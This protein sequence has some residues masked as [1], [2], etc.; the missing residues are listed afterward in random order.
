MKIFQSTTL[1]RDPIAP[2]EAATKAY[3]DAQIT[4]GA[5]TGGLFFINTSPT[6][7]GIVG[8]KQYVAGTV[9]ANRVIL[10]SVTDTDN[11]TVTVFAE[12]GTAFYSP[13]VTITTDPPQ[14][15]GDIT[16]ILTEDPSDKRAYT[17]TANIVVPVNTTVYAVSSTNATASMTIQR[18]SAGPSIDTLTIT[19]IVSPGVGQT[20][21]RSGQQITV[22]GRVMNTATYAEIIVGGAA[23][24]LAVLTVG[25]VDSGGTGWKTITG[26]VTVGNGSGAQVVTARGRNSLGTF[27]ANFNSTNTITLNQT[28]P[29]I[30][31]RTI[32]YPG[33]QSGL[34]AAESA[35]V[36]STVSNFDTIT[37]SGTN[38]TVTNPT[39]YSASK[40]VTRSGGTYSFGTN[41]YTI[42]A[43]KT[44]NNATTTA[45][46]A[47]TIADTAPTAAITITG[48][49]TRLVSSPAGT[50]Y[51]VTITANQQ[52]LNAPSLVASSGTWL[53]SW[54][55]SGTTWTRV[56]QINDTHPKGAQTFS[57][58]TATGLAGVVGSTITSGAAYTVGGF[59]TRTITFPAFARYAPIGT[60]VVDFT[61]TSASYT[62][63]TVL[64]RYADTGVYF[65]GFTIVN[66]AGVYDPTG[67]H[68]FISDEAFAN[69]NTSGTLQLD[70]VEVA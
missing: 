29:T 47:I 30:G 24:S 50:N 8:S 9:P 16:A 11:V 22:A 55:G 1:S 34:K 65:Q 70:I 6:S 4:S 13:T 33:G 57:S 68:L 36:T 31:A 41:N 5:I 39:T 51:T 62:G 46:S 19:G 45:S 25:A 26:T 23:G 32:S 52:L 21:V 60:S 64:T 10:D 54:T 49:P 27:G 63:S 7:T 18:A 48:N 66:S 58:L 38:L 53:G 44:S 59:S 69:S 43:T 12:G 14:V 37:Y 17:G 20:E 2:A 61:K 28:F 3:V 67:D 42:S 40:T 35:T 56:L 15:G